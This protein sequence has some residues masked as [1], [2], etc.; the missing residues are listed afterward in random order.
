MTGCARGVLNSV[1]QSTSDVASGAS[2][3]TPEV[4]FG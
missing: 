1:T 2:V 4:S 3:T